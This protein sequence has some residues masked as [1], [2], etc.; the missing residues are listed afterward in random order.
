MNGDFR[1]NCVHLANEGFSVDDFNKWFL[2]KN[3]E[4]GSS[5]SQAEEMDE[6]QLRLWLEERIKNINKADKCGKIDGKPR[7][8]TFD[9]LKKY[10]DEN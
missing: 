10:L 7:M 1:E 2:L 3:K 4:W 6:A 9:D 8:T 5:W